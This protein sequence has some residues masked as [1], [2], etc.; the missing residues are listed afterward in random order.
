MDVGVNGLSVRFPGDRPAALEEVSLRIGDAEQVALLG[1]SGSGKTTLLRTL[2]GAVHPTAGEVRIG[3]RDPF[4]RRDELRELRRATGVV[5]QGNDL[6]LPLSARMNA[7]VG[8]VGDWSALDWVTAVRGHV[9][10]GCADRLWRL[11]D[12]LGINGMLQDPR[13]PT[14]PPPAAG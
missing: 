4:G 10:A 2:V 13:P 8:T 6:V 11:S 7:L 9:P 14:G 3:G 12:E 1:P 5:R